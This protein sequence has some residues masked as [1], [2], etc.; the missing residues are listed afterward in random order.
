MSKGESM[1][2]R[3]KAAAPLGALLCTILYALSPASRAA[4]PVAGVVRD[5]REPV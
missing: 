4:E 1:L 2:R 3:N 5:P